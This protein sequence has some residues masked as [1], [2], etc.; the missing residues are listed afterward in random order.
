[1]SSSSPGSPPPLGAWLWDRLLQSGSTT[2]Q[3]SSPGFPGPEHQE[4]PKQTETETLSIPK[5]R[6]L[7]PH[8]LEGE[9][10]SS[11]PPGSSL[12]QRVNG[13]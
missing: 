7:F 1:M 13:L 11:P 3:D 10:A 5:G 8:V 9:E 12:I 4:R 6:T 2:E